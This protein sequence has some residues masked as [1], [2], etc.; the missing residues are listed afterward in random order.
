M[1][2]DSI[3]VLLVDDHESW[4]RFAA[5]VLKKIPRSKVVAEAPNGDL[6]IQLSEQLQPDLILLDI[7]L[8]RI[9][10][11]EAARQISGLCPSSRVLFLSENRSADVVE[12]ALRTGAS[13]FVIKSEA[14][15]ELLTAIKAVLEGKRFVSASVLL[16]MFATT[17]NDRAA[18][19]AH[20]HEVEFYPD[21]NSC[22]DGYAR[23]IKCALND[24]NAVIVAVTESH[25]ARL[26]L[27][28][29]ADGVDVPAAIERGSYVP[30][31]A[32]DAIAALT[33]NDVPDS[34]L[35]E[36]VIG[37]IVRRAAKGVREKHAR[38]MV[39]GEI[40]P[41]MLLK[42]NNEGAIRLERLWDE[43]T[44]GYDVHTHCGY[45]WTPC[46]DEESARLFERICSEHTDVHAEM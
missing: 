27:K 37:D 17:F 22:V 7:G 43:I 10:G 40:A 15:R 1:G 28:L 35:C 13:G 19:V 44:R 33:L 45:V 46:Q 14:G 34:D 31:D 32:I 21:D 12:E 2:E 8:P 20:R 41:T 36:M 18:T 39:C 23:F 24:G 38:V 6:A 9:S 11:I 30:L 25:R 3:R 5:A 29:E 4:R 16:P 26:L 42:G